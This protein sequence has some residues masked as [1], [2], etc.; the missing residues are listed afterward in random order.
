MFNLVYRFDP[1]NPGLHKTPVSSEEARLAL[2]QGSRDF[3]EMTDTRRTGKETRIVRFYPRAFGWGVDVGLFQPP[4]V[5]D[6]FRELALR[7][8]RGKLVQSLLGS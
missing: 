6:G 1:G 2:V 8:C 3:A 4:E 5:E 7:I